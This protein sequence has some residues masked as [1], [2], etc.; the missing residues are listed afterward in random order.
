V[1]SNIEGVLTVLLAL[2]HERTL[3]SVH[4]VKR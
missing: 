3:S 4:G 2:L 1:L